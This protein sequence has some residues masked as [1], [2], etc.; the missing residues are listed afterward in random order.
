VFALVSHLAITSWRAASAAAPAVEPVS[1][2][3][4]TSPMLPAAPVSPAPAG[5]RTERLTAFG[6]PASQRRAGLRQPVLSQPA[7]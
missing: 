1:V 6:L 5:A 3:A 2:A 4:V 7:E